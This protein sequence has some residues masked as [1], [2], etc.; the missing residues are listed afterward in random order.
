MLIFQLARCPLEVE[1]GRAENV[2]EQRVTKRRGEKKLFLMDKAKDNLPAKVELEST[3]AAK[4]LELASS[5]VRS[6]EEFF[7]VL[8]FFVGIRKSLEG[9][10]RKNFCQQHSRH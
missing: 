5:S 3:V 8:F 7:E 1:E 10:R 2:V 6:C 9:R 4:E